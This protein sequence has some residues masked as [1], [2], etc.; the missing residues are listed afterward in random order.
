[1]FNRLTGLAARL[2]GLAA[3]AALAAGVALAD[4]VSIQPGRVTLP[5]SGL[6]V[7]VPAKTGVNY[8]LTAS[9]YLDDKAP[10]FD[11]RDVIDE[12]DAA[13]GDLVAGNWVL[14]GYFD[15]GDCDALFKEET[16]DSS[17]LAE[18]DLWGAHWKVAGGLY[19]LGSSLGKKPTVELC[20]HDP[21]TG[22][23]LLLYRFF[24]S[25]SQTVTQAELL[26]RLKSA[27][28]LERAWYAYRDKSIGSDIAPLRRPEVKNRGGDSPQRSVT[29]PITG[30]TV[31][32]PDD[33]AV[34]LANKGDGSDLLYRM[35]PS[36]PDVTI[37]VATLEDADCD[38]VF[39]LFDPP[40]KPLPKATGA[41]SGWKVGDTVL[42]G[43]EVELFLCREH[44][45]GALVAGVMQGPVRADVSYLTPLLNALALATK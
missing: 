1:M 14:T 19:D 28:V 21:E 7:D 16:L 32:I 42:A 3:G 4:P 41:P 27:G 17:W 43:K 2:A 31:A 12:F 6:S 25:G 13:S 22:R 33:G 34:W 24:V 29:L 18:T 8:K 11:S 39:D 36:L 5:M 37:E 35:A 23:A 9:Y 38:E 40:E 26:S 45:V 15:A 30:L 20:R 44:S 10:T